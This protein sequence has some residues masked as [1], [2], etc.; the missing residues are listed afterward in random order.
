MQKNHCKQ[1]CALSPDGG[2]YPHVSEHVLEWVHVEKNNCFWA[3]W[4]FTMFVAATTTRDACPEYITT[5][6][7]PVVIGGR[8]LF[9]W[10]WEFS[11]IFAG[12]RLFFLFSLSGGNKVQPPERGRRKSRK[13]MKIPHFCNKKCVNPMV[14]GEQYYLKLFVWGGDHYLLLQSGGYC[15]PTPSP[16]LSRLCQWCLDLVSKAFFYTHTVKICPVKFWW[17]FG[18]S[19]CCRLLWRVG[20]YGAK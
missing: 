8:G 9:H 1:K 14:W 3:F 20:T 5:T 7:M 12:G 6:Q 19:N 11:Q 2:G 13:K 4:G 17:A 18:R 15:P 10:D 16:P